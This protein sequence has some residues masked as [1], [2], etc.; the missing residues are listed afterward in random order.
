[1]KER[2]IC[3]NKKVDNEIIANIEK[4]FDSITNPEFWLQ[5]GFDKEEKLPIKNLNRIKQV[6]R[7][8]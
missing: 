5:N 8:F 2:E 7:T 6:N 1:M 3:E 4:K